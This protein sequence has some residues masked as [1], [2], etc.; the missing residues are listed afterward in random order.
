MDRGNAAIEKLISE[1]AKCEGKV[2]LLNV[3]VDNE[4]SVLDAAELMMHKL[5][6]ERLY[7]LVNNAGCY[8]KGADKDLMIRTNVYGVK[9]MSEA[10]SEFVD[11]DVGRIVNLGGGAGPGYVA[12]LKDKEK[13][14]LLSS[15]EATWEELEAYLKEVTPTLGD[16][17]FD[18]YGMT[19]ALVHK[20]TEISARENPD[21]LVNSV[22]PGFVNS[23][24][25][26]GLNAPMTP[27]Q[28][29]VSIL[30]TLFADL[31]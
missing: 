18:T 2:E 3:E 12:A 20:Y 23:N 26:V 15:K 14:A 29:T 19:K 31:G 16:G 5:G 28:G 6:D 17:M 22:T 10:F 1:D 4:W 7:A 30:H 11:E 27:E 25:T 13:K 21:L 8:L 9:W 24:M